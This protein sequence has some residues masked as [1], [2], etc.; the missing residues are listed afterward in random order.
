MN[1]STNEF[2]ININSFLII[3]LMCQVMK[4]I[5][6]TI[7]VILVQVSDEIQFYK[8]QIKIVLHFL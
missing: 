6:V 4:F 1:R 5:L 2:K 8:N 7:V 3:V